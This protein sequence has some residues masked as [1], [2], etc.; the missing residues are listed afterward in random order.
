MHATTWKFEN[1][2]I[3][4]NK[5]KIIKNF[6]KNYKV[7]QLR[8]GKLGDDKLFIIYAPTTTSGSHW[9]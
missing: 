6:G 5:I 2:K 9:Y 4:N 3:T 1:N 7:M 8:A